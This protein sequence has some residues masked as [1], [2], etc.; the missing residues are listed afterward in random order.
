MI[1]FVTRLFDLQRVNQPL[2]A[3]WYLPPWAPTLAVRI[4]IAAENRI[5][6]DG[7]RRLLEAAGFVIQGETTLGPAAA[8]LVHELQPD[9]LILGGATPRALE[10]LQH[11]SDSR[12]AARAVVLTDSV[13]TP[14][15]IASLQFG[16]R[17]VVLT[18]SPPD[19]LIDCINT[20]MTDRAWIGREVVSGTLPGL[21]KLETD[22]RRS[23]AFGLTRRELQVLREVVAG[24]TNKEIAER[25]HI[26]E[27]TV[28]A[29]LT[30]IFD[31]LGASNR[32]ELALFAAHH[33]LLIGV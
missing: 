1:E 15:V 3:R 13:D 30:H 22:R 5:F 12:A 19:V 25:I 17:G 8:A 10:L 9:I 4:V 14:A 29:H 26:S 7:L 33:R 31:K 32:V 20:V 16:V 21:R 2:D 28:K 11:L 27:N 6:R 24:Y 23:K 18:D